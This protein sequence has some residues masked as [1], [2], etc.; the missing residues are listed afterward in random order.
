MLRDSISAKYKDEMEA[1]G[2]IR[3]DNTRSKASSS[4]SSRSEI[5]CGK[6]CNKTS[7]TSRSGRESADVSRENQLE[8]GHSSRILSIDDILNTSDKKV[9][10]ERAERDKNRKQTPSSLLLERHSPYTLHAGRQSTSPSVSSTRADSPIAISHF[11]GDACRFLFQR[12]SLRLTDL[13]LASSAVLYP[14]LLKSP[15]AYGFSALRPPIRRQ[16]RANVDRKPRQAYS[17]KQ[18]EKLESEFKNDKY[19][20]VS[21]RV[22]LSTAL[23]LTETQIKTWFQNRRTKWKKQMTAKMKFVQRPSYLPFYGLGAMAVPSSNSLYLDAAMMA[24]AQGNPF[25]QSQSFAFLP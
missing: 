19:L 25:T 18:L 15:P 12:P 1:V 20:S 22:E 8:A 2:K 16:R 11:G 4:H 6:T 7:Y 23:N 21:K 14:S 10:K 3:N 24:H 13:G 17:T 5:S 9:T